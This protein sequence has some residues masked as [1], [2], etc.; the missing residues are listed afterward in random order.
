MRDTTDKEITKITQVDEKDKN[1]TAF[2][3]AQGYDVNLLLEPMDADRVK[4][5]LMG[6]FQAKGERIK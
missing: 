4:G 1:I 5:N 3:T 6:M 2:F